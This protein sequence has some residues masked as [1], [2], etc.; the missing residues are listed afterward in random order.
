MNDIELAIDDEEAGLPEVTLEDNPNNDDPGATLLQ[1]HRDRNSGIAKRQ[2]L[3]NNL[4][5]E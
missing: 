4:N 2:S 5:I 3:T 1:P